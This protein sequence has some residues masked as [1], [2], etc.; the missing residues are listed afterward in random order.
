MIDGSGVQLCTVPTKKTIR[1][2]GWSP[3][4]NKFV[5][6]VGL[7][8]DREDHPDVYRDPEVF[9]Y[10]V[11]SARST[12]LFDGGYE[13]E[14]AAFDG[15][16]YVYDAGMKPPV[17]KYDAVS[18]K[19]EPTDYLGIR[20]SPRGTYYYVPRTEPSG[21]EVYFRASNE[22]VG[23]VPHDALNLEPKMW[24][25]DEWLICMVQIGTRWHPHYVLNAS[26]G[27]V[28]KAA[29][30]VANAFTADTL[31]LQKADGEYDTQ[32]VKDMPLVKP[33]E[34][35]LPADHVAM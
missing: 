22:P 1:D 24:L 30:R 35:P 19:L 18:E 7:E 31:V 26:T 32:A 8:S 14:W 28:R 27:E 20:F 25:S 6:L 29:G 9:M 33:Y 23:N 34:I 11:D 17:Q 3:E 2:L 13:L 21:M 10:D 12:K 15:G 4:G 16:I 5:Y